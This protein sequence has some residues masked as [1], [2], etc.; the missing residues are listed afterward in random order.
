MDEDVPVYR[1]ASKGGKLR[2]TE[3]ISDFVEYR[4][5]INFDGAGKAID[6][7]VRQIEHPY[8]IIAS[9][10]C[11]LE[12]DFK[13]RDKQEVASSSTVPTILI[14]P[15]MLAEEMV[16]QIEP[17]NIGEKK[18]ATTTDWRI[19]KQN[20]STR[21]HFFQKVKPEEDSEEKGLPELGCDFK[22]FFAVETSEV[23]RQ[24]GS[25][26]KRRCVMNV[27][28]R[29]HFSDRFANYLSRIALPGEHLSE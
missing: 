19:T 25:T 6:A 10:D 2:Q 16:K 15:L 8:C 4:P 17:S 28:Y 13:E 29:D 27:P 11:D 5:E 21:Y 7:K 14:C 9:Q 18:R 1:P 22:R 3:I 24:V 12:Q 26:A 20:K 23:Y